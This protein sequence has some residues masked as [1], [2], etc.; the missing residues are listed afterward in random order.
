[1]L[2]TAGVLWVGIYVGAW[3]MLVALF[4]MRFGLAVA[5]LAVVATAVVLAL[6]LRRRRARF[7]VSAAVTVTG[8]TAATQLMIATMFGTLPMIWVPPG[9][10]L[11]YVLGAVA[12]ALLL[13]VFLG[14]RWIRALGGLA[15]VV[16]VAVAV[17]AL[18]PE[19]SEVDLSE[20]RSE[21][22]QFAEFQVLRKDALVSDA[23][24]STVVQV[25]SPGG[26]GPIALIVTADGGVVEI[27]HQ[28]HQPPWESRA[29][30]YPCVAI[31]DVGMDLQETD[32]IDDYAHWCVPD[33]EGWAR[34]DGTGFAR[35]R[36]GNYFTVQSA[37]DFYVTLAN[38]QRPANAREVAV[39][40]KSVRPVTEQELRVAFDNSFPQ[41]SRD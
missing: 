36:D 11:V 34:T 32:E 30:I 17:A 37:D 4:G 28:V 3:A 21:E 15:A 2:I 18:A 9:F 1:M 35:M 5:V 41:G 38:G 33:D 10:E 26:A 22:E 8:V 27:M 39:A 6:V 14:P 40:V 24:G 25:V 20:P 7:R 23:A 13:G 29:H 16:L 12:G 31:A 19:R